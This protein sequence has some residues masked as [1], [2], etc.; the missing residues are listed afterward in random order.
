MKWHS[1]NFHVTEWFEARCT[2][3][4]RQCKTVISC[5]HTCL[6]EMQLHT[7]CDVSIAYIHIEV[8]HYATG[9]KST[10]VRL[11][12]GESYSIGRNRDYFISFIYVVKKM[13]RKLYHLKFEIIHTFS[14]VMFSLDKKK[15]SGNEKFVI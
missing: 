14:L 5:L 13:I 6:S 1:R 4:S 12:N 3:R 15:I 9:N 10:T 2:T 7:W 8:E 11:W